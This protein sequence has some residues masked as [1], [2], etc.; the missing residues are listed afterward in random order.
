VFVRVYS[1]CVVLSIGIG[2]AT[3]LS[4]VQGVLP[5]VH[6]IRKLKK[7][8]G[9]KKKMGGAVEPIKKKMMFKYFDLYGH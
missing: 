9:P 1:V 8:P 3:D 5:T 7:R 6:R 4:P 2:L